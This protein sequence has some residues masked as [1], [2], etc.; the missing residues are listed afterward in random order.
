VNDRR[1]LQVFAGV[2]GAVSILS[3]IQGSFAEGSGRVV[4]LAIGVI[5]VMGVALLSYAM[6]HKGR[7]RG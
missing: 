4:L 5:G 2:A 6:T 7:R 3:L 1:K